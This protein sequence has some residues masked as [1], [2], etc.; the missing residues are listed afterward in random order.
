MMWR[1]ICC[2]LIYFL[3]IY[4]LFNE[5]IQKRLSFLIGLYTFG[6]RMLRQKGGEKEDKKTKKATKNEDKLGRCMEKGWQKQGEERI[7]DDLT[8]NYKTRKAHYSMI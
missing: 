8:N 5:Q 4:A 6:E 3:Q 7:R 2:S 1:D